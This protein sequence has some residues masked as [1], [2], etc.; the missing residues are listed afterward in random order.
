MRRYACS[1]GLL[2]LAAAACGQ[3]TTPTQSRNLEPFQKITLTEKFYAEGA[4]VGDFNRDGKKDLVS[5]PFWYEGPRFVQ[6]HKIFP[7]RSFPIGA[8]SDTFFNFVHDM[9]GDGWDDVIQIGF[10]GAQTHWYVNPKQPGPLW[11]KHLVWPWT[12]VEAPVFRDI[13]RDGKP[14]LVCIS[15]GFLIYLR[16]DPTDHRKPWLPHLISKIPGW[17]QFTHGFGFGDVDGDGRDD[18]LTKNGWFRQPPSLQG[19]PE[20]EPHPFPFGTLGGAQMY[21]YDVDG[22]GD[23]DVVS[24]LNG[25]GYGL[26]WFEHVK[27]AGRVTFK[28]HAIQ[29]TNKDPSDPHQFSQAHALA[30]GDM[31]GDGRI[32]F[33]TGKRF[34]PHNGNDPGARDPVVLYWFELVRKGGV[35]FVPHRI[36]VGSGVGV[37]VIVEDLNGD[38]RPDILTS[39]KKGAFLFLRS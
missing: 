38:G 3:N 15:F 35:R 6:R 19:D 4:A 26:A 7:S 31:N 36:D 11:Q 25:H 13:D 17:S 27:A 5:G 12:G 32:D 24:S 37:E 18:L 8:L 34:W 28:T 23:N 2:T 39:N 10:P 9:N 14:E 21:A 20:W 30:I 22:D 33:V 16:Q 1:L 29:Q